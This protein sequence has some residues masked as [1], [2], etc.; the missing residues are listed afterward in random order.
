MHPRRH[1]LV[2]TSLAFLL[3]TGASFAQTSGLP[4]APDDGRTWNV[5][6]PNFPSPPLSQKPSPD[7]DHAAPT[8]FDQDVAAGLDADAITVMSLTAD[9][10]RDASNLARDRKLPGGVL[11][12][13]A[14]ASAAARF[15]NN[16]IAKAEFLLRVAE[17]HLR[18]IDDRNGATI[19]AK[20]ASIA[21]QNDA[22]LGVAYMLGIAADMRQA[23][24]LA[25][26][27]HLETSAQ[28]I[29]NDITRLS[30]GMLDAGTLALRFGV[31]PQPS[32]ADILGAD[33]DAVTPAMA[34]GMVLDLLERTAQRL[35]NTSYA[36]LASLLER[37]VTPEG[38]AG[39]QQRIRTA[40]AEAFA[41]SPMGQRMQ[42]AQQ[43]S[44]SARDAV[45]GTP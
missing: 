2:A 9:A 34:N 44:S 26:A 3:A 23:G 36:D 42:Q 7:F 20:A 6:D 39:I 25:A 10:A 30:V 19:I 4:Q 35:G 40:Q 11:A 29:R 16:G 28:G 32:L 21:A 5:M 22:D 14:L 18:L 45:L 1:H 8:P 15:E 31:T 24:A 38:I 41:R 13:Q 12:W 33:P 17:M 37:S 27:Q 43:P